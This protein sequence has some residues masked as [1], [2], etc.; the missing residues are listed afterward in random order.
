MSFTINNSVRDVEGPAE[1]GAVTTY[2]THHEL[3]QKTNTVV[4]ESYLMPIIQYMNTAHCSITQ[5]R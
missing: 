1:V 2:Y 4:A 3:R 5:H